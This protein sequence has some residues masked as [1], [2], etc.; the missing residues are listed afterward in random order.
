MHKS[1]DTLSSNTESTDYSKCII[2]NYLQL[3]NDLLKRAP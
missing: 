2:Y 3:E 1:W